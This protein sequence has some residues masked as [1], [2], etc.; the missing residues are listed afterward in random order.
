MAASPL[1]TI[2]GI[3]FPGAGADHACG[4]CLT[5]RPAFDALRAALIHEGHGRDLIHAL[6]YHRKT[7]V[8]RPLALLMVEQLA[9]FVA[10]G[11]PD[12]IVPVPLHRIRLRHRG[13]NQAV[14]LGEML[15]REWGIPLQRRAMERVRWTEP[16]IG[17]AAGLRRDNVRGAF[18]ARASAVAGKRVLL[19][20]DV[21]T[22]GSTVDE[23]AK[24]LKKAGALTVTVVAVAR[25][26]A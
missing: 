13:F 20:D 18:A 10:S 9:D 21:V 7:H 14:L 5:D 6:K 11:R 16:Q 17:L 22:T 25:A 3:P 19:V 8:R 24:A 26:A 1:C 15:A 23:C 2:C 4:A 12:V